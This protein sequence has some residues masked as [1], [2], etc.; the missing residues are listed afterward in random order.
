[1]LEENPP[2]KL[3]F[4]S[5]INS[6]VSVDIQ[7][8]KRIVIVGQCQGSTFEGEWIVTLGVFNIDSVKDNTN[9]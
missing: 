8:E 5:E 9:T 2:L 1:M 6:W 4:Q 3:N 7:G